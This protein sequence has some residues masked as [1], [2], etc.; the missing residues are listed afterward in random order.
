MKPVKYHTPH[1]NRHR[2]RPYFILSIISFILLVLLSLVKP[3]T[4]PAF[5]TE[6]TSVENTTEARIFL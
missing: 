5:D 3:A 6:K 4:D 2:A 1:R